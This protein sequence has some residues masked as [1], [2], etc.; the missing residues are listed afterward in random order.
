MASRQECDVFIAAAIRNQPG[1]GF[2]IHLEPLDAA[3]ISGDLETSARYMNQSIEA[4]VRRFPDQ[5]QWAY[6]RFMTAI[7]EEHHC[8]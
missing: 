2:Q 1:D 7:Y 3:Q 5:Y 4:W 6:R 8:L